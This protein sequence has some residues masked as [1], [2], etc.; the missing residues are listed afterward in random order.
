MCSV[1]MALD[2]PRGCDYSP[3][4]GRTITNI[5]KACSVPHNGGARPASSAASGNPPHSHGRK[6]W[7][8]VEA[9]PADL[10]SQG[11]SPPQT[12]SKIW[13]QGRAAL[14]DVL[15]PAFCFFFPPS[16]QLYCEDKNERV[17][18][19]WEIPR[20]LHDQQAPGN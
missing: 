8:E 14:V 17:T 3:E 6:Y 19:P 18:N 16:L 7:A 4:G 2:S 9:A 15:G 12:E 20:E 1:T 5:Y 13:E 10:K 11:L